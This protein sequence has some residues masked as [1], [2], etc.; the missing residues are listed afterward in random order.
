MVN[1]DI[2]SN[3]IKASKGMESKKHLTIKYLQSTPDATSRKEVEE[4]PLNKHALLYE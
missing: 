3:R 4:T 2:S 1:R